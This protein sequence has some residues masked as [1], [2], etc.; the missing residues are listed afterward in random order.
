[1]IFST[2]V[3]A[4]QYH[5]TDPNAVLVTTTNVT[6]TV[7]GQ[8]STGDIRMDLMVFLTTGGKYDYVMDARTIRVTGDGSGVDAI[9]TPQIFTLLSQAAVARGVALGYTPCLSACS[10]AAANP[11]K[12]FHHNCVVRMGMNTATRFDPCNGS[13][14]GTKYFSVCCPVPGTPVINLLGVENSSCP[15]TP[16]VTTFQ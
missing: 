2:P 8:T 14:Y 13:S 6:V 12:M 1:M 4:Q 16:C 7:Q 11:V 3:Q 5:P 15:G 9:S 10:T